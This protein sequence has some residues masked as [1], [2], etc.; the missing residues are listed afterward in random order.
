MEPAMNLSLDRVILYV[1]D[2]ERLAR[3]CGDAFGLVV[4]QRI[5]GE[6]AVLRAGGCEIALHRV[7]KPW[8]VADPSDRKVESN[9][10]LVFTVDRDL[11]ELRAEL[12]AKGVPMRPIKSYPPLTGPLCDGEDPEGNVFQLAQAGGA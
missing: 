2:V 4:G 1:Q 8:R 12:V 11:K 6:W 5:E 10:K 9:A 3:F 7:G